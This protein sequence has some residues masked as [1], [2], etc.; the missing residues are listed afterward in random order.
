LNISDVDGSSVDN[1]LHGSG[2]IEG[3]VLGHVVG[4]ARAGDKVVR[5]FGVPFLRTL[6]TQRPD[7]T[8]SNALGRVVS[9]FVPYIVSGRRH[10]EAAAQSS[11]QAKAESEENR[12]DTRGTAA[13]QEYFI[14]AAHL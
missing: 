1:R 9:P 2:E 6:V 3:Y 13:T 7:R 5:P 12:A 14:I 8:K 10:A 4:I 11:D